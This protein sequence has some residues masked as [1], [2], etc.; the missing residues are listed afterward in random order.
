MDEYQADDKLI[1]LLKNMDSFEFHHFHHLIKLYESKNNC[2]R[3]FLIYLEMKFKSNNKLKETMVIFWQCAYDDSLTRVKDYFNHI[4]N[5]DMQ[6]PVLQKE[7]FQIDYKMSSI[8]MFSF[9]PNNMFLP[10]E[11]K[12]LIKDG[13]DESKVS[14]I[15]SIS[16]ADQE[17]VGL[18]LNYYVSSAFLK[19]VEMNKIEDYDYAIMLLMFHYY[20][21]ILVNGPIPIFFAM[22]NQVYDTYNAK[23]GNTIIHMGNI[24]LTFNTIKNIFERMTR[25]KMFRF[26]YDALKQLIKH[27]E[28][29]L[30]QQIGD[31]TIAYCFCMYYTH[32]NVSI[33]DSS[34]VIAEQNRNVN[35][36]YAFKL[37][38][39]ANDLI[40]NH[41]FSNNLHD[42][43]KNSMKYLIFMG[44][45]GYDEHFKP[46]NDYKWT[47]IIIAYFSEYFQLFLKDNTTISKFKSIGNN[48]FH[49]LY[50]NNTYKISEQDLLT[51][52]SSTYTK[53]LHESNFIMCSFLF[54]KIRLLL[55]G[56][57]LQ[58]N[59]RIALMYIHQNYK[60][61]HE[62]ISHNHHKLAYL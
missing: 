55:D 61:V 48:I 33:F 54:E 32:L 18:M 29:F 39:P 38:N 49:F 59:K 36:D 31:E 51:F 4:I 52:I 15:M 9:D 7:K 42:P 37:L 3:S 50:K 23:Y 17:L 41:A 40:S 6:I 35:V 20:S 47:N 16:S 1:Q 56:E 43:V 11:I 57:H 46:N 2:F 25:A 53:V 13:I 21:L 12:D 62:T 14:H 19:H 58:A 34:Y 27:I 26:Q 45:I 28:S 22:I 60:P 8:Q 24:Q 30:T 10:K 5:T 44:L